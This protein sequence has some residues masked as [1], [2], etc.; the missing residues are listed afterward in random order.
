MRLGKIERV[1]LEDIIPWAKMKPLR[2]NPG[3][4]LVGMWA[5]SSHK[6]LV[7]AIVEVGFA[8][9]GEDPNDFVQLEESQKL[10]KKRRVDK[11]VAYSDEQMDLMAQADLL[12]TKASKA[13]SKS[14]NLPLSILVHSNVL[15]LPKTSA[16]SSAKVSSKHLLPSSSNMPSKTF[17]PSSAVKVAVIP[18]PTPL[19]PTLLTSKPL[20][21]TH[22]SSRFPSVQSSK[23]NVVQNLAS[24]PL[25]PFLSEYKKTNEKRLE[26]YR[27]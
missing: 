12:K 18:S 3:D 14:K 26:D 9:V 1:R 16:P 8:I 4:N 23:P 24:S 13:P 22:P 2:D 27:G 11:E 25:K 15:P 19:P 5:K 10:V 17:A 21:P 7:I 20:P 6:A